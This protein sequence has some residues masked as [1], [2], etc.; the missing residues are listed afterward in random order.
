MTDQLTASVVRIFAADGRTAVGSGFLVSPK[1]VFTCTQVTAQAIGIAADTAEAPLGDVFL[2]FPLVSAGTILTARVVRWRPEGGEDITVLELASAPPPAVT[3]AFLAVVV[4]LWQ[5]LFQVFG[6]PSRHPEGV[7]IG[8]AFRERQPNGWVQ[9]KETREAHVRLGSGFRGSP[10]WDEQERGIVGIVIVPG[11]A[12]HASNAFAIPAETLFKVW[13]EANR[14]IINDLT[15][16]LEMLAHRFSRVPEY[17][18]SH[19]NIDQ[20]HQAI[21][22]NQCPPRRRWQ[23]QTQS[24]ELTPW[25]G[26]C[27][28]AEP[29][30]R[31]QALEVDPQSWVKPG[32]AEWTKVR[33]TLKRAVLL[34]VPGSG[35][36][37]L[38][39]DEARRVARG[40]LSPLH[41]HAHAPRALVGPPHLRL[42]AGAEGPLRG[43][44]AS[45]GPLRPLLHPPHRRA[46]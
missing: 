23:E 38:L 2:D 3:P 8:G 25:T 7:W 14:Q 39:Q 28:E 20:I 12:S 29:L 41:A 13:P 31:W 45:R 40:Q 44:G 18:P 6:F 15:V 21:W 16:Y 1:Y 24:R 17:F 36:S 10:V 19:L 5:H 33:L 22:V 34:G 30:S 9:L 4:D 11:E 46:L 35:K 27:A 37:W 26:N 43:A 42:G 32:A